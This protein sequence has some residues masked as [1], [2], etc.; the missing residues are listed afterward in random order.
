M[1]KQKGM[2]LIEAIIV[3]SLYTILTTVIY[4]AIQF[5]YQTNN[6]SSAQASEIDNARR[7][8]TS[9]VRDLREMTYG[10]DGTFPV[11]EMGQH[12]IGFYSDIDKDNSVEY[13]EYELATTTLYKRIYGASGFPP[14]YNMASPE[15]TEILSEY[16]QNIEQAT[17]TFYY[18]GTNNA[19]LDGTDLL[20]DVRYIRTQIIVNID[21]VQSPG[22]FMLRSGVAPRN[23]KDNL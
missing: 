12:I 23:L 16:V 22:E 5:L 13:V 18:F 2:T 11:A 9:L 10:E 7:G 8:L 17:S 1:Q 20:T 3:I 4:T 15:S 14:V 21:P 19:L 6:Y